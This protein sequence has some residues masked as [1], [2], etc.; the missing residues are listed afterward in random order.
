M[1]L[2]P[3]KIGNLS[4]LIEKPDPQKC[5]VPGCHGEH[6]MNCDYPVGASL[7]T[8]HPCGAKLCKGHVVAWGTL[9]ICPSH[10]RFVARAK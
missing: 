7:A 6:W 9:K 1:A 4:A 3:I 8:A 10:G 5:R 2:I